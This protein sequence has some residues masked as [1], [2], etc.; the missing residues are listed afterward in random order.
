MG[1]HRL[2]G[3]DRAWRAEKGEVGLRAGIDTDWERRGM[4]VR[5]A[6]GALKEGDLSSHGKR[7][8]DKARRTCPGQCGTW[9]WSSEDRS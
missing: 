6:D 7:A 5:Q 1:H 2:G 3:G 9:S 8:L 4:G